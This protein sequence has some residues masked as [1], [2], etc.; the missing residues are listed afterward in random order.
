MEGDH[1]NTRERKR[2]FN[3]LGD[4]P[5]SESLDRIVPQQVGIIGTNHSRSS[6]LISGGRTLHRSRSAKTSQNGSIPVNRDGSYGVIKPV[7]TGLQHSG[8]I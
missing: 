7:R 2:C 6:Y 1:L 5:S 4:K 8:T 3:R